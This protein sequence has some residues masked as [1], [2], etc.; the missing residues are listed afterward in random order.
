MQFRTESGGMSGQ[1]PRFESPR[2]QNNGQGQVQVLGDFTD[3]Y[4]LDCGILAK[5]KCL[6][7]VVH[8]SRAIS[9]IQGGSL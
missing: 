2:E 3:R 6:G 5:R 9:P 1:L 4:L 8:P 7:L